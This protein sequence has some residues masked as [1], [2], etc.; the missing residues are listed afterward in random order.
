MALKP[1]IYKAVVALSDLNRNHYDTVRLTL[2]QHPSETQE[3]MMVRLLG[4]FL[5]AQEGLEFTRGLSSTDEPDLWVKSL[6]GQTTLWVEVGEPQFD[7][8]KKACRQAA[9]VRVLSFNSKSDTWWQQNAEKFSSL[10]LVVQQVEW[11]EVQALTTL[12]DR[13]MELSV[14][15]SDNTVLVSDAANTVELTLTTLQEH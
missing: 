11:S 1:T 14:T 7:R 15:V 8:L 2:A 10:P 5:A 12:L 6:D 4:Y 13:T 3:R 9:Q